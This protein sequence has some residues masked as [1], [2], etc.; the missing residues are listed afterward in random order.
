[1]KAF[2]ATRRFFHRAADHL[3]LDMG[4]RE[5]MLM[6]QREVQVQV[7]IE[8]DDGSLA[9]FVGFRVQ[10]DK[11]RGP[12]KGGLR[13][14]HEVD[15]D[16]TRSLAS[17]MTW[18]TAVVNLPYGGAKGGIGVDPRSLSLREKERLTRTFVDQIHD[19][20]GPDTD[21]PAPDMGTDFRVM[22]WFRNQW[23]KYHGFNP[24]VI[25]GKP[26]EEYGAKGREEATGRGVGSLTVK[27]AKRLGMK[28]EQSR[29]AIQG[30]G[31]VGS[32]AAKFL[33]ESQF[34]IVAVSDI[35][36]T[37]Y[38][39]KG[40]DIGSVFHH[41]LEHPQGLLEGYDRCDVLPINA[42]LTLKDVDILIPAALG[43][44]I[45]EENAHQISAKAIIEAA[46]GP[47]D[48]DADVI[49]ND[50]GITILPDILANA[51]GVTVSYFEWV[52]NRQHYRWSLDRVRQELDRTLSDAFENV[53]Q[54]AHEREISLRDA[55]F[56]IGISR[57][58]RASELAGR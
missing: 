40:L 25:T 13:Y 12:M 57:V 36:G 9:N 38:C 30:F 33:A 10:H 8:R 37:Y 19:I 43:G 31:N 58:R 20:I 28:P 39:E 6:P 18:K 7:T 34:P 11:S 47:I 35:S 44:V 32:H 48:P 51:G 45:T 22:A 26:V 53:W 46:N 56:M 17:L 23:E 24:A 42:L 41:K 54:T 50:R 52:Q 4:V 27:T 55:A 14:H 5:S 1:M 29:V 21:I 16:E 15:L 3:D 2:D 49:L